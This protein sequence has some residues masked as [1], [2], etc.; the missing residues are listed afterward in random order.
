MEIA[1]VVI[2]LVLGIIFLL[3][4]IFLFPGISVAGIA[5][6]AFTAAA[7]WYAY[8]YIGAGAGNITLISGVILMAVAVWGFM[9]SKTL[10][11]MSLKTNVMGRVDEIDGLKIKVGDI[12]TTLSRLAPMGK[13]KINGTVIEAKT[14]N[15]FLDPNTEVIIKEVYKTN[16]LVEKIISNE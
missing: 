7:V 2:L 12:G 5:G 3:L 10:D 15:E 13:I 8:S 4:E 9:K 11:K 16:V 1:I 6:A 14:D